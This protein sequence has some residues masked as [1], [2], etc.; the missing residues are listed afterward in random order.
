MRSKTDHHGFTR[1]WMSYTS[2]L[3]SKGEVGSAD[4]HHLAKQGDAGRP[5]FA[6]RYSWISLRLFYKKVRRFF[7]ISCSISSCSFSFRKHLSSAS[8]CFRLRFV[9]GCAFDHVAALPDSPI[10]N[11]FIDAKAAT[12]FGPA[13]SLFTHQ[14]K[15]HRPWILWCTFVWCFEH[16]WD[17]SFS[18]S[19]FLAKCPRV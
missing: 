17:T 3:L 7:N 8:S 11:V 19:S 2:S 10:D 5:S 1:G 13:V 14:T 16:S 15:Q 12:E 18:G 6:A 4:P 9:R